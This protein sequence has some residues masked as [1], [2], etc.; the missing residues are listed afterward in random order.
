[1]TLIDSSRAEVVPVIQSLVEKSLKEKGLSGRAVSLAVAGHDG[2]IK[3]I[4]AGR[5]PGID[6]LKALF[7]YLGIEIQIGPAELRASF[8]RRLQLPH[9]GL[10]KCGVD[11]WGKAQPDLAPLPRPDFINDP[12]AF[13]VSATGQS[14][15]PEGIDGG[16]ICLVSPA[17]DIQEGD[18]I[19]IKDR[20]GR[21]AIKRLV[22]MTGDTLKLRGWMPRA[23]GQQQSFEEERATSF[24][25]EAYP[26]VAVF[27]GRPGSE[28]CSLV[29]DPRADEPPS[30]QPLPEADF[31]LIPLHDIQV[32][33]GLGRQGWGSSA[34]SAIAFPAPWLRDQ[35][36]SPKAASL[37]YVAGASMEPT[38]PDGSTVLINHNRREPRGRRIYVFRNG[39]DLRVKRLELIEE[40]RL[41]IL[42]DNFA[43]ASELVKLDEAHDIEIIG[44]V[45]WSSNLV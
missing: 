31:A 3:D 30:F 12:D 34:V 18:R 29:P 2:L 26:V 33:A 9:L 36:I 16:A 1:M 23:D 22:G 13:Y 19:W 17:Q 24:V 38:L 25:G 35:G 7:D 39:D 27:K 15:I 10:A 14:M 5:V 42:S 44:E 6:R 40:D 43:H 28:N 37:V 45:V 21:A 11:G 8:D 32:A 41:L 20:N 4:R